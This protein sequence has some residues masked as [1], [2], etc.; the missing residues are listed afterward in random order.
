MPASPSGLWPRIW[1]FLSSP[2]T[3]VLRLKARFIKGCNLSY[4]KKSPYSHP[5]R[6]LL[7]FW[8]IVWS[9]TIGL[10]AFAFTGKTP[11]LILSIPVFVLLFWWVRKP[12]PRQKVMN[13][14]TALFLNRGNERWKTLVPGAESPNNLT[15]DQWKTLE[16]EF[17]G[18]RLTG[19]WGRLVLSF[20]IGFLI[21]VFT[22]H[23]VGFIVGLL[24]FIFLYRL[25]I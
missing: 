2:Q 5:Y 9:I 18:G 19:S 14:L 10:I 24:I 22:S 23:L 21:S 17:K 20:I 25:K 15:D 4:T 3:K 11:F 6:G 13:N 16:Y 7:L 1:N 8:T 12:M